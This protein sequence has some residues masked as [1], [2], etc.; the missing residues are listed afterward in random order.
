M[1]R[2][3]SYL[4]A[5]AVVGLAFLGG[6]NVGQFSPECMEDEVLAVQRDTNPAHGLS[7]ACVNREEV[8]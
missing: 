7:W 2:A 6:Y 4:S 3:L 1:Q 8:R 5:L